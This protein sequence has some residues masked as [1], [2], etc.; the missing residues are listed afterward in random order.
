MAPGQ[1]NEHIL[2]DVPGSWESA[3]VKG[4]LH[5]QGWGAEFGCPA[6]ELSYEGDNVGGLI[7]TT[8]QLLDLLP[9]LD[10]FEG[11]EY[12]RQTATAKLANDRSME[13]YV[14]TL[15]TPP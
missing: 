7:F 15:K 10:Q 2:K 3:T 13:V 1:A 14:Y 12:Q 5:D 9:S 6:L 11:A 8:D 4:F